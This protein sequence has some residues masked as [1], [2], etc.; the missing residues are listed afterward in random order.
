MED[1]L[2]S[3]QEV[4][5]L[6]VERHLH[7]EPSIALYSLFS[8]PVG[9]L[10]FIALTWR[11]PGH[12]RTL[13]SIVAFFFSPKP[14]EWFIEV[15]DI[16]GHW[17]AYKLDVIPGKKYWILK[18]EGK[19]YRILGDPRRFAVPVPLLDMK[20]MRPGVP[21]PFGYLSR[22]LTAWLFAIALAAYGWSY[23][24]YVSL[25][26]Y[27]IPPTWIDV[28]TTVEFAMLLIWLLVMLTR[29]TGSTGM[30]LWLVEL[31]ASGLL[32]PA[33]PAPDHLVE[34]RELLA[35]SLGSE[36]CKINDM[37]QKVLN[38]L[39]NIAPEKAAEI[40][41]S[42]AEDAINWR[43]RY[44]ALEQQIEKHI[45]AAV[46]V[47]Q[48]SQEPRDRLSRSW[49]AL[50]AIG[51]IAVAAF[52]IALQPSVHKVPNS[53]ITV[54]T[55]AMSSI[56]AAQ[57]PEPPAEASVTVTTVTPAKPPEPPI[58]YNATNA[59]ITPAQLPS[60]VNETETG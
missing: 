43:Y 18:L 55:T 45:E 8:V 24:A 51:A 34:W 36:E 9:L 25:F 29:I 35:A 48:R 5:M 30:G 42:M 44:S 38:S 33:M 39:E 26:T 27:H 22:L 2:R 54:T 31:P 17:H 60:P 12:L 10:V 20:S 1:L 16:Y 6:L 14:P 47:A 58:E 13:R 32:I 7:R 56:K 21:S 3:V 40:I 46:A 23:T 53:T 57:P 59:T 15:V 11:Y 41:M 19:E 49:L 28:L 37:C 4:Y 50:L 52:I